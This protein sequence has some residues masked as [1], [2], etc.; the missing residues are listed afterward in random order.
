MHDGVPLLEATISLSGVAR[1]TLKGRSGAVLPTP[2]WEP[3]RNL[4]GASLDP[5]VASP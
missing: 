1:K 4:N 3:P 2:I 5:S